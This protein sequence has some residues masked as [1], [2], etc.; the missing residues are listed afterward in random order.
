M[1]DEAA[2]ELTVT[3][4]GSKTTSFTYEEE[5]GLYTAHQYGDTH[6]DG[7]TGEPVTYRNVMALYANHKKIHL[8]G[9]KVVRSFYD[10]IGSGEGHLACDGK[11]IPIRWSHDDYD[12]PFTY[13]LEDGTPLELGVGRTY[14]AVTG[15]GPVA[16]K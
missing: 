10:L 6:I 7:N 16:Y 13:T 8:T 4:L 2:A 14:I 9:S 12:E 1:S 3:F 5:A 15:A 11:I